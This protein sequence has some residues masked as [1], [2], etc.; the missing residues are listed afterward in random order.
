MNYVINSIRQENE[1]VITDTTIKLDDGSVITIDIAHYMPQSI[2]DIEMGIVNRA[3]SEQ[4]KIDSI[5]NL[6]N[7]I[8]LVPI[9]QN[10]TI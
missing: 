6:K 9:N 5:N 10:I 4:A 1:I 7:I 8:D 2:K 3:I